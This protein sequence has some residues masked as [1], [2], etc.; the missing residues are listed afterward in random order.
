MNDGCCYQCVESGLAYFTVE[1]VTNRDTYFLGRWKGRIEF[2]CSLQTRN[3][4]LNHFTTAKGKRIKVVQPSAWCDILPFF[5]N[6]FLCSHAVMLYSQQ[7]WTFTS[8][9]VHG[10]VRP[11]ETWFQLLQWTLSSMNWA[12]LVVDKTVLIN[13]FS[14]GSRVTSTAISLCY[15]S[16][17]FWNNAQH[18]KP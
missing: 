17:K 3:K 12:P 5:A 18:K 11:F 6:S 10:I 13:S 2:G 4:S 15:R 7:M 1:C 14:L 9:Q 16:W 8:L